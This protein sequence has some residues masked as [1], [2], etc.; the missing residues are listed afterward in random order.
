MDWIAQA[1]QP[2]II[3]TQRSTTDILLILGGVGTLI[4]GIVAGIIQIIRVSREGAA[5][6]ATTAQL[7]EQVKQQANQLADVQRQIPSPTQQ[8]AW[9]PPGGPPNNH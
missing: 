4:A 6:K 7:S 3:E 5:N 1:T 8:A 2:V 9:F